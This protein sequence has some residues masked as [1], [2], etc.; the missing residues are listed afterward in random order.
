LDVIIENIW[1]KYYMDDEEDMLTNTSL[2][3]L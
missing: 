2:Q 3:L 1:R